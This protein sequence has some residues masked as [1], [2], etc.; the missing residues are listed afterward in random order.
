MRRGPSQQRGRGDARFDVA[1][2]VRPHSRHRRAMRSSTSESDFLGAP[3]RRG[4]PCSQCSASSRPARALVKVAV[5]SLEITRI[6]NFAAAA[7]VPVVIRQTKCERPL[8]AGPC[9]LTMPN[10]PRVTSRSSYA[11]TVTF[12]PGE[13]QHAFSPRA[14]RMGAGARARCR[15]QALYETCRSLCSPFAGE[16]SPQEMQVPRTRL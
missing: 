12:A 4:F 5:A 16:G 8:L 7:A 2:D 11:R 3:L 14:T 10:R 13:A 6:A 15:V 1:L 9:A